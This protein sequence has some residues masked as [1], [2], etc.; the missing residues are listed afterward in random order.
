M[1]FRYSSARGSKLGKAIGPLLAVA[2]LA[3]SGHWLRDVGR[4]MAHNPLPTV[5]IGVG[6]LLTLVA[7]RNNILAAFGWMPPRRAER[8]IT[9][10]LKSINY[11][12]QRMP[13]A[14]KFSLLATDQ[15]Q[16]KFTVE[17]STEPFVSVVISAHALLA[18]ESRAV[19]KTAKPADIRH[20]LVQLM[21]AGGRLEGGG[22]V[23]SN[24]LADPDKYSVFYTT[25]VPRDLLNY[26]EVARRI[27]AVEWTLIMAL[28]LT[29]D[30][31][32]TLRERDGWPIAQAAPSASPFAENHSSPASSNENQTQRDSSEGTHG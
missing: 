27:A 22:A 10:W 8:L 9:V 25:R 17:W 4:D 3:T 32:D 2:G 5:L 31:T 6:V 30:L 7:F 20:L 19:W 29:G 12:I 26:E 23:L 24:D 1:K 28:N 16:R 14:A 11:T 13:S 15:A 21:E 18:P